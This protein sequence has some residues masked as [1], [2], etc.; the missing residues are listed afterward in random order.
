MSRKETLEKERE[1]KR[2]GTFVH[3]KKRRSGPLVWRNMF[4]DDP[5][6]CYCRD[7][8][9]QDNEAYER[10][11]RGRYFKSADPFSMGTGDDVSQNINLNKYGRL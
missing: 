11:S 6:R 2:N 7:C 9:D 4:N 3:K 8:Q 5:D 1:A 10:V